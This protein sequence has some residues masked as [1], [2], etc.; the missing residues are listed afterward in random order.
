MQ[1]SHIYLVDNVISEKDCKILIDFIQREAR[2]ETEMNP[3]T[4]VKANVCKLNPEMNLIVKPVINNIVRVLTDIGFGIYDCTVPL[5]RQ[6]YGPTYF[7][8][9]NVYDDESQETVSINQLRC[10]S[11]VIAIN[12]DYKGG[13]FCFPEQ[14]YTVKLKRGQALLFPPFWTHPHYTNKLHN[15]TFRYTITSWFYGSRNRPT[16]KSEHELKDLKLGTLKQ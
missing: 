5:L 7:H 10:M 15:D 9:D 3:H 2:E 1:K 8:T 13:E 4:N 12:D 6:I 14:N 16:L 11:L